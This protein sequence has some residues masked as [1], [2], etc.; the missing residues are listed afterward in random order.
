M[1][2]E[3]GSY[4]E[5]YKAF[6]A[7]EEGR[8]FLERFSSKDNEST[9]DG[10]NNCD[11]GNMSDHYLNIQARPPG[12]MGIN[13]GVTYVFLVAY[14]GRKNVYLRQVTEKDVENSELKFH[15]IIYV[16]EGEGKEAM[17]QTVGHEVFAHAKRYADDI[18]RLLNRA[19]KDKLKA[20]EI[21]DEIR[22]I[23]NKDKDGDKD[24]IH[25]KEGKKHT[26]EQYIDELKQ[27]HGIDP[28]K[29]DKED[30]DDKGKY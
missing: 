20:K 19:K 8:V 25:L 11:G 26:Y 16:N 24:H 28:Q 5:G 23:G 3:D 15:F 13:D 18:G 29:L 12:E 27:V 2:N 1:R 30:K 4:K 10:F 14:K 6:A 17:A 7:T 22:K 21:A 9:L